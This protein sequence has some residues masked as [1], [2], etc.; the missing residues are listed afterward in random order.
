MIDSARA[1][2][3]G[4]PVDRLDMAATIARCRELIAAPGY[5]QHMAM[6]TA[7]LVALERDRRLREIVMRSD[8]VSAD[9]QG[10]VLA[11]R[12][13]GDPLPERVPGI[14]LMDH[15]LEVAATDRYTVFVLGAAEDVLERAISR[16]QE[17]HPGLQF[18]G[19][20]NGYFS[21][22]EE[23]SVCAEIRDSGADILFVAMST[24]RKEYFLGEHG[25]DLGVS[26]GMGVG[27]AIDVAAGLTPRAPE[28]WQRLGL[29]WLYRTLQEPKRMLGRYL[30]SNGAFALMLVR[31]L[32]RRSRS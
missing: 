22:A 5:A 29:E 26:F 23:Q 3:L 32:V 15:L 8:V 19:F 30:R 24:P 14:D 10:I 6:N 11:A 21:E 9:G 18:A 2:V 13:L 17:R 16:L 28:I 4:C 7:K 27:G 25:P 20:R 31:A 12:L 1:D